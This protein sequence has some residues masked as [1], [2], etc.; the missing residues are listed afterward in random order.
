MNVQDV[1]TIGKVAQDLE[2]F[3][4]P[5]ASYLDFLQVRVWNPDGYSYGYF[6]V[7]DGEFIVFVYDYTED[8][9]VR[10]DGKHVPHC[11]LP[12]S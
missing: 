2:E 4:R 12:S 9:A 7:E 10:E 6:K 11:K 8:V 5:H 3:W 1:I